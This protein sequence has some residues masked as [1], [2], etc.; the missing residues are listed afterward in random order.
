[1]GLRMGIDTRQGACYTGLVLIEA[2]FVKQPRSAEP[3]CVMTQHA[4]LCRHLVSGIRRV[5][6]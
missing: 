4:V 1:M 6:R 5:K 3:F 2:Y